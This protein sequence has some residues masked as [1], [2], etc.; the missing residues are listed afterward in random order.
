MGDIL[1][2]M[3][4]IVGAEHVSVGEAIS[5]DHTH[6]ECL[7]VAPVVPL[8]VVFPA[9][10]E[11]VADILRT[12]NEQHVTVTARGGATGLSGGCTPTEDGLVV[13]FERMAGILDIDASNHVAVVQP[14]VSLQQLNDALAPHGF[15]Y[16]VNPGELSAT[17]GG[18]VATNA[19]GMRAVKYGVTRHH[20]LGLEA[21]LASG[22]VIR[23]GGR[24]VKSS[25]GYDLTQLLVGSE[26]TLAFV[27]EVTLKIS[28]LL[29]LRA[30][31]LA[32]FSTLDQVT[33]AV[34]AIVSSGTGPLMLEYIDQITMDA[35]TR[36]AGL[37]LGI[38][39]EVR[40]Q[41][42]A[43]LVVVLEG[44]KE[45][46]LEEDTLTVATLLAELGAVDVFVL[47]AG[48]GQDLIH[49]RERAFFAAKAMGVNDIVD[50]VVPRAQIPAYLERAA[51]LAQKHSSLV[52]GCGHAGDGNVHLSVFQPDGDVREELVFDLVEAGIEV[53]GAITGEHG[54][55]RAKSRYFYELADPVVIDLMKRLKQAFDPNGI[56]GPGNFPAS[57]RAES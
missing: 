35:I 19:G 9:D 45:E 21:V 15:V 46:R 12:C 6:D 8:G 48:A 42:A 39:E 28:P 40:A 54:L 24:F 22:D 3:V 37:D 18:N 23:T 32:P 52:T 11:Q 29:P 7:T 16:P 4:R 55:G 33:E 26:G 25:T 10:T 36:A 53:G 34:P 41:S 2:E 31:L 47:P 56:L 44:S 57:N 43:Y 27:T 5:E 51:E 17:L 50:V 20:V 38:G 1:H 13:S 14:G 30:T 49:A